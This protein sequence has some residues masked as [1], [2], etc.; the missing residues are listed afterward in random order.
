MDTKLNSTSNSPSFSELT[1]YKNETA[2]RLPPVNIPKFSGDWQ[3]WISFI[4]R[5]NTMFHN[6]ESVAP[7]QKFHYLKSC[8]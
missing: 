6:N 2:M 3:G 8:L 7:V 5:F 4:Y 1:K